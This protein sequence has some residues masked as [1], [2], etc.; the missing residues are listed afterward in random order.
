MLPPDYKHLLFPPDRQEYELVYAGKERQEDVLADT[1]ALPLQAVSAF[2]PAEAD[3]HNQLIFGDNL[4]ALATLVRL[5]QDGK[6][7]NQHGVPGVQLI[8]IDP[9]SRPS[10]TSRARRTRRLTRTESSERSFS[11]FFGSA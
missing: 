5:K 3:W 10:V 8:Y 7:V 1:M 9:P 2:G 6:L 11:S 4:Q